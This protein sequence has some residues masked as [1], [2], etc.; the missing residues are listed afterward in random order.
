MGPP[1]RI[2]NVRD[3][4]ALRPAARQARGRALDAVAL[5]RRENLTI[6]TAARRSGVSV[7]TIRKYAGSA[8]E[9]DAFGRLAAKD[10]DRLYRRVRVIG[11]RGETFIDVRGSRR[12]SLV[13][14]YWNAVRHYLLAGD[15]VP[16]RRFRGVSVGGEELETDPDVIEEISRRGEVSFEDLYEHAA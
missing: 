16:L 12:A 5:A 2:R 7:G 15:E 8:L 10:A 9:T 4:R 1:I 13:A 11:S 3:E 6:R 14:D